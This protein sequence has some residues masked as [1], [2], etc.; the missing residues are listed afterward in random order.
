MKI[1]KVK[2]L[3][4]CYDTDSKTHDLDDI[5]WFGLIELEVVG[6]LVEDREDCIIVAKEFTIKEK[7]IR[8]LTA[9]PKKMIVEVK[10]L[11]I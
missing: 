9:I 5:E 4:M 3:D 2:L 10:Y 1:V 6:W 8:H 7:S 11:R